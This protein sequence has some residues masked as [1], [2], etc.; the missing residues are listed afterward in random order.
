[1]AKLGLAQ[2][3]GR[4]PSLAAACKLA[5]SC[6]T[7]LPFAD[8]FS[9]MLQIDATIAPGLCQDTLRA[10][11]FV[12]PRTPMDGTTNSQTPLIT[13]DHSKTTPMTTGAADA[14]TMT[15]MMTMTTTLLVTA[16]TITITMTTDVA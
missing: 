1:M 5:I 7:E 9:C 16:T 10:Y 4:R 15:T 3:V 11:S 6:G 13:L 2:E 12:P 14:T 8:Y